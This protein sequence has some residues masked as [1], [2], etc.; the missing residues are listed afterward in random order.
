MTREILIVDDE[1]DIRMLMTGILN[2]EGY[3]TREAANS[4]SAPWLFQSAR[5]PA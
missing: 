4:T 5:A 3:A 1:D 2:D